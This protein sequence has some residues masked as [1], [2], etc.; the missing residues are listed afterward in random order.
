MKWPILQYMN[1]FTRSNKLV[2]EG[3]TRRVRY[4]ESRIWLVHLAISWKPFNIANFALN[5]E[6]YQFFQKITYAIIF[7]DECRYVER[8]ESKNC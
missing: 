6:R 1:L 5:T 8:C 3:D 7:K 4:G 2:D